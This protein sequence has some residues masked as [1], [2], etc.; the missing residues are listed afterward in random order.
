MSYYEDKVNE[1]AEYITMHD[2]SVTPEE[3]ARYAVEATTSIPSWYKGEDRRRALR[4]RSAALIWLSNRAQFLGAGW[5][6]EGDLDA[7]TNELNK[8]QEPPPYPERI[9]RR[10]RQSMDVEEFDTSHDD[11][12]RDMPREAVFDKCL[13]WEGIIGYGFQIRSWIEDIYKVSL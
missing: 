5:S 13:T 9:M 8:P 10:V 6:L 2:T 7:M 1:L 11:E 12:I 4:E 3:V